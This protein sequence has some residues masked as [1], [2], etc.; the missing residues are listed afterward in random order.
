MDGDDDELRKRGYWK[1]CPAR[2][3]PIIKSLQ[4]VATGL[5]AVGFG[6]SIA[7]LFGTE[8]T[9]IVKLV[10]AGTLLILTAINTAGVRWVIRLQ[11]L[12]LGF[13]ALAV[14]DFFLGV[15]F[16]IDEEHGVGHISTRQF[17]MNTDPMY[18]GINC[19]R[20][21]F[22]VKRSNES[23]FTVF[24]VFFANFLGVLAGVNMSGDLKEPHKSI[25]VGEL[26]AVGVSSTVCFFFI[27]S[28]GAVADRA[29]L[30]CDSL[31]AEK[32]SLT[33]VLFLTGLYV[34]SLSST[35]GSLLGTPRVIQSIAAEGIIPILN[36]LAAGQ[37]PNKDPVRAGI[38]MMLVAIVFVL[39]GDLNELAI[40]STMPFMITYAFVNYSYV[41][42]AMSYDLQSVNN[43]ANAAKD[44]QSYGSMGNLKGATESTSAAD[45]DSLFPERLQ[46]PELGGE[47]HTSIIG[48]PSSWYSMFSNRYISF[49]GAIVNILILLFV[50]VWFALLHF[51]ALAAI[52][53]YIGRVC[54]SVF[55]G[56]S[57]FSLPHM[58]KTAF[59][60]VES[61]GAIQKSNIL[62]GGGLEK[63][64]VPDMQV[65]SELLNEENPDYSDRKQYHH[66]EHTE[67]LNDFD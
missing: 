5:V 23:F 39:L 18:D 34:S 56:I 66:A 9:K 51:L 4:A 29:Y 21:G 49:V 59:S 43:I 10:A 7:R 61:L 35:I 41:S 24:G 19:S 58:F 47:H 20:I 15:L 55:P 28:L 11:L 50:N 14:L 67:P 57:H 44:K 26:A 64:V 1:R 60:S 17:E 54:P 42:L 16:T 62:V 8:D 2:K 65:S 63:G 45:L 12:L 32:V 30:L 48:Q 52:Y 36:P 31:I 3:H 13:L 40:L 37:G 22:D 33:G 27:I 53:I 46:H 6:E 25:P 38:V